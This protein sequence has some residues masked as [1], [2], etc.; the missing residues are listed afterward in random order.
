[1]SDGSSIGSN[2]GR[3]THIAVHPTDPAIIY[4]G[5]RGCGL[6]KT[7]NGGQTWSPV[8]DM[9]PSITVEGVAIAPSL[10]TRVYLVTPKGVFRSDNSGATWNQ[11]STQNLNARMQDGGN[12]LVHPARPNEVCLTA[13]GD[14]LNQSGIYKSTDGGVTWTNV[15]PGFASALYRSQNDPNRLFATL[16]D[17]P[18]NASGLYISVDDGANWRR[19]TGCPGSALPQAGEKTRVKMAMS[20]SR[21]YVSYFFRGTS[22]KRWELYRTTDLEC[23]IGGTLEFSWEKGWSPDEGTSVTLWSGLYA[24]PANNDYVY[25]T[26]TQFWVSSNGGKSFSKITPQPHV[27]YHGFAF[28]PSDSKIFFVGNDGGIFRSGNH[29]QQGAWSLIGAGISNVE[30]YDIAD[31]VTARNYLIGGTQD[32]G[33][34]RWEGNSSTWKFLLGGDSEYNEIDPK[35]ENLLYENGQWVEQ[36]TLWKYGITTSINQGIPK[37]TDYL[38]SGEYQATP[39]NQ[40]VVHPTHPEILMVTTGGLYASVTP[41]YPNPPAGWHGSFAAVFTPP[42]GER[43]VR[44]AVDPHVSITLQNQALGNAPVPIGLVYIAGDRGNI[45]AGPFNNTWKAIYSQPGHSRIADLEV[46]P[47]HPEILYAAFYAANGSRLHRLKR[48]GAPPFQ[49]QET[50]ITGNFPSSIRPYCIGVDVFNPNTIYVGASAGV[51]KGT[52]SDQGVTWS[53][54]PF[55]NGMPAAAQVIDLEVHPVTGVMR[56]G[57]FGRGVYEINTTTETVGSLLALEGRVTLLRVHDLGTRYGPPLD[58]IDVEVVVQLDS[59]PEQAFGFSLREGNQEADHEGMLSLLRTAFKQN[60]KIRIDYT[61]TGIR[62]GIILRVNLL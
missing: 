62:N 33:T 48:T 56:A 2:I 28:N 38:W 60:R 7:T 44:I 34:N 22:P 29:A 49:F 61:R 11:V 5:A 27:D 32:N 1:M 12:M 55:S 13:S 16:S 45:Y 51:Y 3:I 19:M 36:L 25:A 43:L 23:S 14:D 58:E 54:T 57:T 4:A 42:G 52:S 59:A 30:F 47:L 31:A 40:M 17:M 26:G 50:D 6:W 35:N 21:V 41:N 15:L 18:N 24:D 46:D 53:W 9:L 39:L 8:A 10:P 20:K 37:D